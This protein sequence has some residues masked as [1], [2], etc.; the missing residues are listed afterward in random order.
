VATI[1]GATTTKL[2]TA[3]ATRSPDR[4]TESGGAVGA[5]LAGATMYWAD[6]WLDH[7]P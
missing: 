3:Q 6:F 2:T 4:A 1:D 7:Y 5:G